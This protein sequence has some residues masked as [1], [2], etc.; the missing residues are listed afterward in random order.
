MLSRRSTRPLVSICSLSFSLFRLAS[1]ADSAG[2]PAVAY[3]PSPTNASVESAV[4]AV[5]TAEVAFLM[6]SGPLAHAPYRPLVRAPERRRTLQFGT[7]W[8]RSR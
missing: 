2:V 4:E 8:R 3:G 6:G 1:A 5:R 7:R